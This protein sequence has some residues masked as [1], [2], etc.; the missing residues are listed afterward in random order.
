MHAAIP[1]IGLSRHNHF[2]EVVVAVL[3]QTQ[4]MMADV[5]EVVTHFPCCVRMSL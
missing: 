4:E 5:S 3:G 1:A 2:L